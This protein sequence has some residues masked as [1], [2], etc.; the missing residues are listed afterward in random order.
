MDKRYM[1]N[2][3]I[4]NLCTLKILFFNPTCQKLI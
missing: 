4:N 1:C 2:F 3:D